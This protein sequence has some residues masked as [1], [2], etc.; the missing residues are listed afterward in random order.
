MS[1]L[2]STATEIQIDKWQKY[3]CYSRNVASEE[4]C[5]A[6]GTLYYYS[7]HYNHDFYVY[8]EPKCHLGELGQICNSVPEIN[9]TLSKIKI[10]RKHAAE[11][12]STAY[13]SVFNLP[14]TSLFDSV[15]FEDGEDLGYCGARCDLHESQCDFFGTSETKCY[16]GI[17]SKTEV[18]TVVDSDNV[19][20]ITTYHKSGMILPLDQFSINSLNSESILIDKRVHFHN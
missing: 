12:V 6:Y 16:F 20:Q 15:D 8:L 13:D 7:Y 19:N 2:Y 14:D 5:A 11:Y 1:G 18:E 3:S 9:S 4:E 10:R 17:Y